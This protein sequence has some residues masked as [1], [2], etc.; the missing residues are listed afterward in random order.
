MLQISI[1]NYQLKTH[2]H[3]MSGCVLILS[4]PFFIFSEIKKQRVYVTLI[5]DEHNSSTLQIS[6]V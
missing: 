1:L 4:I 2:I 6:Y 5:Y 3:L